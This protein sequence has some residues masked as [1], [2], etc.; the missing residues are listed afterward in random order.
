MTFFSA[1]EGLGQKPLKKGGG[2]FLYN[3]KGQG[4]SVLVSQQ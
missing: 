1:N 4:V 3:F 2:G